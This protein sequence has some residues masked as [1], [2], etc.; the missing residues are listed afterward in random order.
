MIFSIILKTKLKYWG[1]LAFNDMENAL[2]AFTK[3]VMNQ[4]VQNGVTPDM[5]RIGK[6]LNSIMIWTD[7]KSWGEGGEFV[8][9]ATLL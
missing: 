2:Y 5:V 6:E 7:G 8:R 1:N 3:N 4:L 9:I